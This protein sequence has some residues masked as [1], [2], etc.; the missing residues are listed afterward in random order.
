MINP[1]LITAKTTRARTPGCHGE[2]TF[3]VDVGSIIFLRESEA[4]WPSRTD[5][6]IFRK[7]CLHSHCQKQLTNQ[8]L[9]A[10][11]WGR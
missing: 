5:S 2:R 8:E 6:G 11:V 9:T 4:V 3:M 1:R 10:E 7:I